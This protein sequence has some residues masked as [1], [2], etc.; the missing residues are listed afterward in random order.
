MNV[1]ELIDELKKFPPDMETRVWGGW[2]CDCEFETDKL[3][4]SEEWVGP[5][6]PKKKFLLID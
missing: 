3:I 5:D 4:L 2:D 6:K 1:Q